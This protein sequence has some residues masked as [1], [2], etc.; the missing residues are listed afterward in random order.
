[1]LAKA[2]QEINWKEFSRKS[3]SGFLQDDE[4]ETHGTEILLKH[5]LKD[6]VQDCSELLRNHP[7]ETMEEISDAEVMPCFLEVA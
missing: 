5:F 2:G 4:S 1:M 7:R 3:S 6:P